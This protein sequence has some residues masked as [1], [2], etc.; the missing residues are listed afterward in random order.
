MRLRNLIIAA[1]LVLGLSAG[2]W[3]ANKHPKTAN[4]EPDAASTNIK[5]ADIPASDVSE[6]DI[7]KKDA[8]QVTVKRQSGKWAIVA[9]QALPAD[10]DAVASMLSNISPISAD[11]IANDKPADVGQYGLTAPPLVVTLVTKNGKTQRLTFGSNLVVGSSTYAR[12]NSD[13]KV[14]SVPTSTFTAFDKT[15]ADLRDK[16]LLPFDQSK[17]T[18]VEV[19]SSARDLQF[20]KN[21]SGDWQI[22]K[23]KPMRADGLAVDELVRKLQDAKMDPALKPEDEQKAAGAYANGLSVAVVHVSD[24]SGTHS[25][26]I[27][28]NVS[29]YY[30]RSDAIPGVYKLNSD[31][32]TDITKSADDFRNKKIFDFGFGDLS[33]ITVNQ[34]TYV[35]SG[36]DW[37]VNGTK[38]DVGSMQAFID[39]LRDLSATSF[40]TGPM[41]ALTTSISVNPEGGKPPE[42]VTIAKTATG[43]AAQ[44]ANDPTVYGLDAASVNDFLKA[45]SEIKPAGK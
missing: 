39:K 23:P 24:N 13:P 35:R 31:L 44:R 17:V 36:S 26:Q 43:Y 6:I 38:L 34:K 15:P 20:A 32:G 7:Q 40:P 45:A 1:A 5:L 41:P 25:L 37:K 14:Y 33:K 18:S 11:A 29:D 2:V 9:P 27:H 3:W 12:V 16:R 8:P 22:V 10:Q 28:K 19:A 4:P 42:S 30:G 21:S